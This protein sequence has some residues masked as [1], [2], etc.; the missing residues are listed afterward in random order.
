MHQKI[1]FIKMGR[2]SHTNESVRQELCRNF[3][4]FEIE[5]IDVADL[6]KSKKKIVLANIFFLIK[7][8]GLDLLLGRKDLVTSFFRTT[9]IFKKIKTLLADHFSEDG[10]A[11][12]FQ[13]Q[14]LFD[15]SIEGMPHFVYTDHTHLANLYYPDFDRKRLYSESWIDLEKK[16]YQN[17]SLNFTMSMNISK[18]MVEQYF[19]EPDKVVCVY[20]GSNAEFNNLTLENKRYNN[21]NILFVGVAWKRKGGPNLVEAFK[22]VLK[23]HPDA[24]LTIVG[25]SPKVNLPN[26]Q[27]VGRI[28][29]EEVYKYYENASIFCLPTR[30]EPF[31]IVLIEALMQKLP[32]VATNIGAI[33]DFISD[34]ENGYLVEPN[35]V[36]QLAEA[37]IDLVG[38]PKKCQAFGEKG[39]C[40]IRDRYTWEKVGVKIKQ[41]IELVINSDP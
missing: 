36:D 5:T 17:A 7:E 40:L 34:G 11:F 30:L 15:A 33:P 1:A 4:N 18:S 27:V 25:S 37:L 35:D 12:S 21:K 23:A 3:P 38:N 8:Y 2:F 41:N 13:T 10:Y 14:S 29:V 20:A 19:C 31:G 39:Y 16:I 24:R 9:Y 26:C 6:I 32:V 28:S 22:I